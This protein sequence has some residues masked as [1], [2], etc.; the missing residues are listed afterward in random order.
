LA[1]VLVVDDEVGVR[2]GVC[3]FLRRSGHEV[4]EAS[5]GAE[6][7]RQ[8]YGQ[9]LDLVITDINMPDVDGIEVI[10]ALARERP[11]LPIIAISGGGLMPK[12][13]LLSSAGLLGAVHT[14]AK[15]FVLED[16]RRVVDAV[17]AGQ[18]WSGATEIQG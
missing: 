4:M 17:L 15:P 8:A 12:D 5:G 3:R 2:S 10:M 16:L 11:G 7:L 9:A 6:A 13:L 1:R 14:V 18:R